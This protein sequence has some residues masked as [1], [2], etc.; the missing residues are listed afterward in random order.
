L[1]KRAQPIEYFQVLCIAPGV[2]QHTIAPML[3]EIDQDIFPQS[4]VL[5]AAVIQM[6]V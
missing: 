4:K 1:H 5:A 2:F 6:I 3:N